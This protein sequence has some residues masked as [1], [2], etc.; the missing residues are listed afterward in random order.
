MKTIITGIVLE[1]QCKT[2]KNDPSKVY[3]TLIV[4]ES[5]KSFP[6]LLR[7]NIR[8]D[9]VNDVSALVGKECDLD[10]DVHIFQGKVQ[11]T[12]VSGRPVAS[13]RAA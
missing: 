5:G 8:P 2:A 6:D 10:A 7:L 3:H 11:L 12:F 1:H 9:K 4:Y 13:R